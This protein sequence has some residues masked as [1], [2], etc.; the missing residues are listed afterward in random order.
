MTKWTD[1][2]CSQAVTHPI[3]NTAKCCLTSEILGYQVYPTL[4]GPSQS[5]CLTSAVSRFSRLT[6]FLFCQFSYFSWWN[7]SDL[8]QTSKYEK[9]ISW[10]FICHQPLLFSHNLYT[11]LR[12]FFYLQMLRFM[13]S[14]S[15]HWCHQNLCPAILFSEGYRYRR[16][17][18]LCLSSSVSQLVSAFLCVRLLGYIVGASPPCENMLVPS[19]GYIVGAYPPLW[20]YVCPFVGLQCGC[21]PPPVCPFNWNH[22]WCVLLLCVSIHWDTLWVHPPCVSRASCIMHHAW[23]HETW[24]HE[25]WLHEIWHH[26]IWRHKIW[27]DENEED[28]FLK[29]VPGPSLHNLTCACFI[30]QTLKL[31]E[32]LWIEENAQDLFSSIKTVVWYN[33]YGHSVFCS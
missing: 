6:S 29:T 28:L 31:A 33:R 17:L 10:C 19:L 15:I 8:L 5:F 27:H 18:A 7:S 1:Y 30:L 20:K 25:I 16:Y 13:F 14:H 32:P 12:L 11:I 3:T 2:A 23:C 21:V 22:C 24:H 26:K 9:L 4:H